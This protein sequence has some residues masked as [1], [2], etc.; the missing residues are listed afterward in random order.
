[1]FPRPISEVTTITESPFRSISWPADTA[2][3]DIGFCFHIHKRYP[4]Y[5]GIVLDI[6][7]YG[8]G[9]VVVDFVKGLYVVAAHGV[10]SA[11]YIFY[12]ISCRQMFRG[13]RTSQIQLVYYFAE[14]KFIYLGNKLCF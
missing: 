4:R 9:L 14:I 3:K 5:F 7:L 2:Y 12:N 8:F 1:M 10:L 11:S 13:D 6:K